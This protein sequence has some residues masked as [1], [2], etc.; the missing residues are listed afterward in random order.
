[1]VPLGLLCVFLRYYIVSLPNFTFFVSVLV[2]NDCISEIH[3]LQVLSLTGGWA[4]HD[5]DEDL[6]GEEDSDDDDKE[7]VECFNI[8]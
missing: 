5:D 8:S 7:K 6:S 4:S 2:P 3:F 1:M